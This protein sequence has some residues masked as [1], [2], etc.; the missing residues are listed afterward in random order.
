MYCTLNFSPI[1]LQEA[2]SSN[3]RATFQCKHKNTLTTNRHLAANSIYPALVALQFHHTAVRERHRFESE[4]SSVS[5]GQYILQWRGGVSGTHKSE[6][7]WLREGWGSC[8][9]MWRCCCWVGRS[10]LSSCG[11]QGLVDSHV[12]IN[13]HLAVCE[14]MPACLLY[15][16]SGVRVMGQTLEEMFNIGQI[17]LPLLIWRF[18]SDHSVIQLRKHVIV[19]FMV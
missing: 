11:P 2:T 19:L 13:H 12:Q 10:T 18:L 6:G 8:N 9:H 15:V 5:G 3:H 7:V 14:S 17:C 1:N 4:L 16:C